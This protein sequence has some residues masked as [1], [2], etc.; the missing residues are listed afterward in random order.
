[1]PMHGDRRMTQQS[2]KM[3]PP[4][5]GCPC[6]AGGVVMPLARV[7]NPRFAPFLSTGPARAITVGKTNVITL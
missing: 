7:T 5:R 1:M 6:R 3:G 2:A 4:L